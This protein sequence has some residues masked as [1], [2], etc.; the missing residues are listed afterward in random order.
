MAAAIRLS[1]ADKKAALISPA[2]PTFLL[3]SLPR[4]SGNGL[5]EKAATC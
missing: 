4:K 3:D 2:M 1:I 5:P